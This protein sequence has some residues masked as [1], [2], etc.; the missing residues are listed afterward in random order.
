MKPFDL[1][2][3]L[4][5]EPVCLRSGTKAYI[6][7][8][9]KVYFK[10]CESYPLIVLPEQGPVFKCTADGHFFCK[11]EN[12]SSLHENDVIGMWEESTETIKIG[13]F[14]F[15]KGETE[16]LEVGEKY[17]IPILHWDILTIEITWDGSNGDMKWLK[18]GV[19][20]KTKEAALKHARV[21]IAI[22][23]G[24]TSLGELDEI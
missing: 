8:D 14:E 16:P 4:G 20:H 13:D 17:Y 18:F 22:S 12:I 10:D 23:L 7:A 19:V 3:A 15:P 6:V 5:G 24:K 9:A 21:L 11:W 2:A 1:Q